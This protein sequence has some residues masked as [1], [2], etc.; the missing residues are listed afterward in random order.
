MKMKGNIYHKTQIDLTYNSNHI[1]GSR[2]THDQTRYIFETNTIGVTA[3]ESINVNDIVET[4]NRRVS[5]NWFTTV[6]NDSLMIITLVS[7]H[8]RTSSTFM[9]A[10]RRFIPSK[11]ATDAWDVL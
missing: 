6:C 2:L 4:V 10:S 7:T 8:W 11:T 9:S 3:D 1:E 5:P